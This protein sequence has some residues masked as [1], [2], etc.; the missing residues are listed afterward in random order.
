MK[1]LR[2]NF[3]GVLFLLSAITS[4]LSAS[5]F[6]QQTELSASTIATEIPMTVLQAKAVLKKAPPESI[7]TKNEAQIIWKERLVAAKTVLD[8]SAA[9][10]AFPKVVAFETDQ[11]LRYKIYADT[12]KAFSTSNVTLRIY[13]ALLS[14]DQMM[15]GHKALANTR[16]ARYW[17]LSNDTVR[18][19]RYQDAAR[20][21]SAK[22]TSE[23]TKSLPESIPLEI[24]SNELMLLSRKGEVGSASVQTEVVNALYWKLYQEASTP[25]PGCTSRKHPMHLPGHFLQWFLNMQRSSR[26]QSID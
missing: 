15:P 20:K 5:V 25:E 18:A 3:R 14:D 4:L 6:S 2:R 11:E 9:L 26:L 24:E 22:V 1:A 21:L 23:E 12:A 13:E 16:L 7:S 8:G 10:E 17:I 19:A